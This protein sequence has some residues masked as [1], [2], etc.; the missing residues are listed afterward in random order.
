MR[1]ARTCTLV[2]VV[3]GSSVV[4][5]GQTLL[6]TSQ[7]RSVYAQVSSVSDFKSATGFGHWVNANATAILG[8]RGAGS[9]HTSTLGAS[10][11]NFSGQVYTSTPG[12]GFTNAKGV[13]DVTFTLTSATQVQFFWF[14]EAKWNLTLWTPTAT[15]VLATASQS[16][17]N[18][19][20]SLFWQAGTYRLRA[21]ADVSDGAA[22]NAAYVLTIVPAPSSLGVVGAA[23]LFAARRRR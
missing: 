23:G 14:T 22:G 15:R 13:F 5:F 16:G 19:N 2:F 7:E 3:S 12:A 20:E 6:Y 9:D 17:L 4:A 1:T 11:L 18:A 21:D 8:N 10:E